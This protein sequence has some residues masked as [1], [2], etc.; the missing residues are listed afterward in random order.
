M[1][2][3]APQPL[4]V[5]APAPAPAHT[6]EVTKTPSAPAQWTAGQTAAAA[7]AWWAS[8]E[9]QGCSDHKTRE[10]HAEL[11]G[12]KFKISELKQKGFW[13][14][15]SD[16]DYGDPARTGSAIRQRAELLVTISVN[17]IHPL[18]VKHTKS[19]REPTPKTV[20]DDVGNGGADN[21]DDE[22]FEDDD[23]GPRIPRSGKQWADVKREIQKEYFKIVTDEK[24]NK[25]KK[26]A[27][28]KGKPFDEALWLKKNGVMGTDWA[29]AFLGAYWFLGEIPWGTA[30]KAE[31]SVH[32][33]PVALGKG[34]RATA[35][36]G[37]AQSREQKKLENAAL[38]AAQSQHAPP[39][40]TGKLVDDKEIAAMENGVKAQQQK[41]KFD[42]MRF[43]LESAPAHIMT[44]KKRDTMFRDI[45]DMCGHGDDTRPTSKQKLSRTSGTGTEN[46]N[47]DPIIVDDDEELPIDDAQDANGEVL[48]DNGFPG[49]PGDP[50]T[51][52]SNTNLL[53][54]NIGNDG[55]TNLQRACKEVIDGHPQGVSTGAVF[56]TLKGRGRS[57]LT[58][59]DVHE[60]MLF[61]ETEGH[62]WSSDRLNYCPT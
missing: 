2:S 12:Y 14:M 42:M 56:G 43:C 58:F 53:S 32:L 38:R 49:D 7:L 31:A 47:D 10:T 17:K 11:T 22:E 28:E 1:A 48:G 13:D 25:D 3:D 61:L 15:Q 34:Q 45:L 30:E 51:I 24:L 19:A 59:A 37:R 39:A 27:A 41:T 4:Q 46:E 57:A 62:A 50:A 26:K 29:D 6:S 33:K 40:P 54:T 18:F 9:V 8:C 35:G 5:L 23:G 60:T 44:D 36:T 20:G 52:P 16:G 21:A 55:L